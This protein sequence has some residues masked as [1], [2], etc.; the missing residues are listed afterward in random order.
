MGVF[1]YA[2]V[3]N[4]LRFGSLSWRGNAPKVSTP[5]FGLG[6]CGFRLSRWLPIYDVNVLTNAL[7]RMDLMA[8]LSAFVD[9]GR[10]ACLF[11]LMGLCFWCSKVARQLQEQ[12]LTIMIFV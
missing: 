9:V 7:W 5:G 4:D 3:K 10:T 2:L 6:S 11:N 12:N 8:E 1:F